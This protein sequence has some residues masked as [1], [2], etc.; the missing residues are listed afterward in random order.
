M[1]KQKTLEIDLDKIMNPNP[2]LVQTY[3]DANAMGMSFELGDGEN[4][5]KSEWTNEK[6]LFFASKASG[7]PIK[8]KL[9]SLYKKQVGNT[10]YVYFFDLMTTRDYYKN[11]VDW[12]RFC[13]R[14]EKPLIEVRRAVNP[15]TIQSDGAMVSP[16]DFPPS[17]D[18]METVYEYN[19]SD[20][21]PQLKKWYQDGTIPQTANFYAVTQNNTKYG[22]FSFEEWIGLDVPDLELLGK[23]GQ[24]VKGLYASGETDEKLEAL[25]RLLR[26]ELKNPVPKTA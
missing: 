21:V 13:G 24:R 2:K 1:T 12:T 8:H 16:T 3:K 18:S 20:I 22:G 14:W 17:I 6:R 19:F 9:F 4:Y 15:N 25:K 23:F 5:H 10:S 26:E 11:K 7:T